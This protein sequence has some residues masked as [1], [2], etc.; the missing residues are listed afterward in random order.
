M[1]TKNLIKFTTWMIYL[2]FVVCFKISII[3]MIN[4]FEFFIGFV[5]GIYTAKKE[6][7]NQRE[8]DKL[9]TEI[10]QSKELQKEKQK[11]IDRLDDKL[12]RLEKV[13]A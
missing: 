9:E 1:I 2:M 5:I 12:K 3:I 4:V 13:G 8:L 11:N 6:I 10:N 7:D